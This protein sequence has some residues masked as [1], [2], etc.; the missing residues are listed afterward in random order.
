MNDHSIEIALRELLDASRADG[1]LDSSEKG[2]LRGLL[3]ACEPD[4][5]NFARNHAFRVAGETGASLDWLLA[6]VRAVDAEWQRRVPVTRAEALFEPRGRCAET[7]VECLRRTRETADICVFTITHDDIRDALVGCSKR[8]VSVRILTDDETVLE[9]GSDI[10]FLHG[11]GI[12]VRVDHSS[13]AYSKVH[14]HHK[15]AVLDGRTLIN[16]SFN[17]TRA[18][19]TRHFE[20]LV[21]TSE[22]NLTKAFVAEFQRIWDAMAPLV[23]RAAD[24]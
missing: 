18:A 1:K 24:W 17:W 12:P 3:A 13:P 11:Q 10:A 5:L 23:S 6:V 16:G 20:N 22:E 21:I 4:E 2:A 7:I 9:P 14:M 19:A 15:F 8:G